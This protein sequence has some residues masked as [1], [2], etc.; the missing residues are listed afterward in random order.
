MASRG[1]SRGLARTLRDDE[2]GGDLPA[3][4]QGQQGNG[5]HIDG[6]TEQSDR[7]VAPSSVGNPTG[8]KPQAI[9]NE[10]TETGNDADHCGRGPRT[11]M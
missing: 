2:D 4:N 9:A 1:G 3:A 6:V 10:L 7:P 5:E 11:N 8:D